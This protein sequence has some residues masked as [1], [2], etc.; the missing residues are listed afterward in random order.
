MILRPGYFYENNYG[1]L[2]LIKHQGI[3]GGAIEPTVAMP[4]IG[5][6][7][8]GEVAAEALRKSDFSGVAVRELRGPRD[9]TMTE[10]TSLL[11]KAIGKPELPYVR[12]P[13]EGYVQGLT[14]AGFHPDAARAF[15][16][17][18]QAFN[19]GLIQSRPEAEKIRTRTSFEA[20]ADT[21][22]QAYRAAA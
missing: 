4:T 1:T 6:A 5:A 10:V 21:F 22:A 14:S 8:I 3:N 19:A 13:D 17:M 16:E 12:F 2:A 9:L 20:F 11:G 15:L 18:A 7:D